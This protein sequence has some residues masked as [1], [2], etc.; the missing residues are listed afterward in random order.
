MFLSEFD[1]IAYLSEE[2]LDFRDIDFFLN[3]KKIIF[4]YNNSSKYSFDFEFFNYKI[5]KS[6]K[7]TI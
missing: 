5:L 3:N 4:L 1:D 6:D 2:I 7:F